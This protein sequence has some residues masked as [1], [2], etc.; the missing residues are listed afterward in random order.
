[1]STQDEQKEATEPGGLM[2][3]SQFFFQSFDFSLIFSS[4]EEGH[5][6]TSHALHNFQ[7]FYF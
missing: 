2:I 4:I 5:E 6:A 1:V 7:I 3:F